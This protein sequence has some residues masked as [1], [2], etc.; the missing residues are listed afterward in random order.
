LEHPAYSD[1]FA[2]YSIPSPVGA[3]WQRTIDGGAVAH[4]E[5]C[6]YGHA[7]KKATW[8]YAFGVRDLPSLR[9]T[10]LDSDG[11]ALVERW[12][13]RQKAKA[14]VSWCGNHVKSGE[15]R[16]RLG[17]KAAAATPVAFRD[18]LIGIARSANVGC[19]A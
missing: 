9:R 17:K 13:G 11:L 8:L 10:S 14:L 1:A 2:A 12:G 7:A 16:P 6:H 15:N 18:L 19:A 3:G 4:V 5:Q